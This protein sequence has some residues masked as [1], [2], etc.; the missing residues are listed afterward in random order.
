M[1]INDNS[2]FDFDLPDGD[3][4]F[5]LHESSDFNFDS[6]QT[7]EPVASDEDVIDLTDFVRLMV[8][9]CPKCTEKTEISL[10]EMPED[11]FVITCSSCN[12][13]VHIVKESCA[14]RATRKSH[15]INCANCGNLLD[16]H[17]HCNSCGTIF[18]D[19]FVTFNP[20]DA[21]RKNRKEFI[22]KKI[23][24]LKNLDFS[25]K[26]PVAVSAGA[27]TDAVYDYSYSA[28]NKAAKK[29][30]LSRKQM[31]FVTSMIITIILA[32]SAF[33][34][35]N[36]YKIRQIYADNYIK[37]LYGIKTG[38]DLNLAACSKLKT[39]W[40]SASSSGRSFS[41]ATNSKDEARSFKLRTEVD[42][43]MQKMKET[44]KE[45]LVAGT[46]L[47]NIHKLY[48]D[49]ETLIASRPNTLQEFNK[50]VESINSRMAQVSKE[51]KSNLPDSLKSELDKA[52]LK[53]S[54]LK[55]F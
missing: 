52:R 36:H 3:D 32:A 4:P 11:G 55:D 40:E 2:E 1:N 21:R 45:Y 43:Y 12:K 25:F 33:Y 19:Y 20:E 53:Y 18:P 54:N 44:P 46:S 31:I 22:F 9:V 15:E 7:D 5:S 50:S 38:I 8:C 28:S 41:P 48:L 14:K 16:Q 42:K 39:E 24:A 37:T 34:A 29:G 26:R 35:Y 23:N 30:L 47:T 13:Q 6:P 27:H 51:L 17:A 49:S 10:E